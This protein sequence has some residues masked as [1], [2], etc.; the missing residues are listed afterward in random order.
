VNIRFIYVCLF[1][2]GLSRAIHLKVV[3]DLS[4]TTPL[5]TFRRFVLRKSLPSLMISDNALT[6]K[7]SAEELRELFNSIE[8]GSSYQNE[9][10]GRGV[11]GIG[12]LE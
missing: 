4:T 1:I 8:A 6:F 5:Q 3:T 2:C 12:L 9:P 10:L 11:F 7:S